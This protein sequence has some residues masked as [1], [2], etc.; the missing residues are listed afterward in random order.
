M[1]INTGASN[2]GEQAGG[3]ITVTIMISLILSR[4]NDKGKIE[5]GVSFQEAH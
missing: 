2:K 3:E 5:G 4:V 1:S